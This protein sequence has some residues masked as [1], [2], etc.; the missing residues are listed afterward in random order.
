MFL[1][2]RR[3][4]ALL[5]VIAKIGLKSPATSIC[6]FVCH[7][8]R[9]FRLW[10]KGGTTN[11]SELLRQEL[12]YDGVN[13]ICTDVSI[14]TTSPGRCQ[15]YRWTGASERCR[16][17]IGSEYSNEVPDAGGRWLRFLTSTVWY[18]QNSCQTE[19]WIY[20]GKCGKVWLEFGWKERNYS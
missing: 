15:G 3:L 2:N 7:S 1:K 10:N 11:F 14:P 4:I 13:D 18:G 5:P 20:H 19:R 12:S 9:P 6:R 17:F 8:L 16:T